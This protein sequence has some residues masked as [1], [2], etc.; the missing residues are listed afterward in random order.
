MWHTLQCIYDRSTDP[1]AGKGRCAAE[2][3]M[4]GR[5]P[6]ISQVTHLQSA[7][8]RCQALWIQTGFGVIS[9]AYTTRMQHPFNFNCITFYY[10]TIYFQKMPLQLPKLLYKTWNQ[11]TLGI[12]THTSSCNTY[13]CWTITTEGMLFLK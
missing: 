9:N 5:C 10:F 12:R 4:N 11:R 13:L 2:K 1:N 7:R 8:R 3:E 6:G